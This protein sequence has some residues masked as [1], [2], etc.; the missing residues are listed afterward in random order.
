MAELAGLAVFLSLSWLTIILLR[1]REPFALVFLVLL[2]ACVLGALPGCAP[3]CY[4]PS[5]N[6]PE[7]TVSHD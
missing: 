4:S 6:H 5:C 7:L 1:L 3:V 2:A